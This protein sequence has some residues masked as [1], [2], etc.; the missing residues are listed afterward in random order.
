MET[1]LHSEIVS[2]HIGIAYM[3]RQRHLQEQEKV[4]KRLAKRAREKM[5]RGLVS[6]KEEEDSDDDDDTVAPA[7][8]SLDNWQR[9]MFW[10]LKKKLVEIYYSS[11]KYMHCELAFFLRNGKENVLA[12][13]AAS[14][15]GV[16]KKERTFSNPSYEWI[17]LKTTPQQAMDIFFFCESCVGQSYDSVGVEWSKFW[18]TYPYVD[19]NG[20]KTW[21]C[22]SFVIEALQLMGL[23]NTVIPQTLDIDDIIAFLEK[24][25]LRIT[26]LMTPFRLNV[27]LQEFKEIAISTTPASTKKKSLKSKDKDKEKKTRKKK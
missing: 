26:N 20:K 27:A 6:K 3:D 2:Q 8:A 12:F 15:L 25:P 1:S 21:W 22:S 4:K 7:C 5:E 11:Q 17:F 9:S 19:A 24:H 16:F 10:S 23:F 13:G 18:P 14:D